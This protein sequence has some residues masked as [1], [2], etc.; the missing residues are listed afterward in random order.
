M[1][2]GRFKRLYQFVFI[3]SVCVHP[4]FIHVFSVDHSSTEKNWLDVFVVIVISFGTMILF[5]KNKNCS[6]LCDHVIVEGNNYHHSISCSCF[7]LED[8]R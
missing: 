4:A 8:T 5:G 7:G 6:Y 1:V 2:L 3:S